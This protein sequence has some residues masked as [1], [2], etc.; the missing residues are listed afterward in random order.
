MRASSVWPSLCRHPHQHAPAKRGWTQEADHYGQ[1]KKLQP[2]RAC[3]PQAGRHH[4]HEGRANLIQETIRKPTKEEEALEKKM[5]E[6]E[7][8]YKLALAKAKKEQMLRL[9][10]EKKKNLPPSDIEPEKQNY[11]NS[12]QGRAIE[13]AH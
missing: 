11:K 12:I 8:E 4:P 3:C 7:K 1:I 10:E 6:E 9:E 2:S 13:A 5:A